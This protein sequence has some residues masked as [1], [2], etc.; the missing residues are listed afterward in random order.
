[1]PNPF[2]NLPAPATRPST[3]PFRMTMDDGSHTGARIKVIG[4]GGGGGNAVNRMV[5][6]GFDGVQFLVA[7]TDVQSLRLNAA[8]VNRLTV[9]TETLAAWA[10]SSM[11]ISPVFKVRLRASHE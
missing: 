5:R 7:N 2:D 10:T 9:A 1:M 8:P 6:E 3:A 4:V 11:R